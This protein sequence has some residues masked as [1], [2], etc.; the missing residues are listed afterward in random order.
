MAKKRAAGCKRTTIKFKTKRGKTIEFAGR[1]GASCGPRAKPKTG[2][3]NPFKKTL[4]TA[5]RACSRKNLKGQKFRNCV[6]T[7]FTE[8][9]PARLR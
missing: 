7:Q 6:S 1:S 5:S 2:H 4:A 3:L 8:H 9:S